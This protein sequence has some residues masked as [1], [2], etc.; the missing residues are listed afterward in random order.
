[1]IYSVNFVDMTLRLNPLAVTKYLMETQWKL[2]PLKRMD[3]KIFKYEKD[4]LF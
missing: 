4:G 1:M 3:I 2:Y